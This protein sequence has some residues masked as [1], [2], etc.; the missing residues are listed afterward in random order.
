MPLFYHRDGTPYP[1]ED[2]EAAVQWA[3]DFGNKNYQS[4][5]R[6]RLPNG[7][8]VSTVWL[9]LNHRYD[10]GK[11]LIFETMVFT[12]D[13]FDQLDCQRYSSEQEASLGHLKMVEKWKTK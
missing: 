11:P 12:E 10:A 2:H 7:R 9:G 6:T 3:Q 5:F 1:G 4:L 8:L 13:D